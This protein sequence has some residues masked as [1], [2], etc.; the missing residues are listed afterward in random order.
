MS[1]NEILDMNLTRK[2]PFG[3]FPDPSKLKRDFSLGQLKPMAM[4]MTG[5][6]LQDSDHKMTFS[7]KPAKKMFQPL[8]YQSSG[9][10]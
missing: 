2:T 9:N 5:F 8:D 6:R 7:Y 10:G 3:L 4:T 1:S